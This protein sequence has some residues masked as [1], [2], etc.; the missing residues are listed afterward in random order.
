[1]A[2][3]DLPISHPEGSRGTHIVQLPVAQKFGTHIVRQAHPAKQAQQHEQQG[4]ARCKDGAE[5][6]QQVELWHGAPN[7]NEALERQIRLA[8]KIALNR[9]G[10]HAQQYARHCERQR[11][12][13]A[14]PKAVNQLSQQVTAAVVGAQPVVSA[15]GR[16][17]R[18]LGK[19]VQRFRA[20]GVGRIDHPIS[21]LS[22]LIPNERVQ[23]IGR[24]LE[25]SAE[26]GLRVILEHWNIKLALI[27]NQQ[28]SIIRD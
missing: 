13:D 17:V 10:E 6:D 21:G 12:Q 23:V 27:A 1:M 25:V 8:T 5:N 14:N 26:G 9:T 24:C 22:E 18:R 3:N 20:I 11:K 4:K 16:G 28:G 7:F 19:V 2:P 15:W